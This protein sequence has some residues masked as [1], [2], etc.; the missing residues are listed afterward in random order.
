MKNL[1]FALK[2]HLF[3][4]GINI[5][6]ETKQFLN[7]KSSIWSMD[8]DYITCTGVTMKFL[9]QYITSNIKPSSSYKL[10]ENKDKLFIVPE[11]GDEIETSVIFPPDYMKDEIV[12]GN[13]RITE[14]V[15]TYTDRIRIQ[16]MCGCANHCKFCNASDCGYD[17]NDIEDLDKAFKIAL[18]Q[19]NARHAFI[20]TNNVKNKE[21][22][23][24][25]TNAMEYFC[26][27]YPE[28]GIDIMTSPRGF[29]SYT[30]AT[31]YKPYLEYIKS[32]GVIYDR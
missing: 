4:S 27:K 2:A 26:G 13:K 18:S 29:D 25:L 31:Q 24:K 1:G 8:N 11:S 21:G 14:Y 19:S 32:V 17:F 10:I 20:S 30:D 7:S 5:P 22:F 9:D 12:I 23:I 16:T 6:E 28:M 3:E 15:N